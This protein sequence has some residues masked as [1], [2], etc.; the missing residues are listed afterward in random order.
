MGVIQGS[1]NQALGAAAIASKIS[2]ELQKRK[3]IGVLTRQE[4]A[5]QRTIL[6]LESEKDSP[7]KTGTQVETKEKLADVQLQKATLTGKPEDVASHLETKQDVS[8]IKKGEEEK[9]ERQK[10]A[11]LKAEEEMRQKREQEQRSKEFAEMF[12]DG[13]RYK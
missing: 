11:L 12:T 7:E 2:P 6:N 9:A 5:L 3:E 1:I 13:G 4:K 10:Q 8:N